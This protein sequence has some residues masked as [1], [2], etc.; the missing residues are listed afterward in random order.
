MGGGGGELAAPGPGCTTIMLYPS[1]VYLPVL[2]DHVRA[3][4]DRAGSM[5]VHAREG[6]SITVCKMLEEQAS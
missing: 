5:V 2:Y 6:S 1:P 4:A 3:G